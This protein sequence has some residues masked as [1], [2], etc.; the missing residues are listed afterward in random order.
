ML[1]RRG[2]ADIDRRY[3]ALKGIVVMARLAAAWYVDPAGCGCPPL[4]ASTC[5]RTAFTGLGLAAPGFV[6]GLR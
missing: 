5:C 6:A 3:P 1:C 2:E 4:R